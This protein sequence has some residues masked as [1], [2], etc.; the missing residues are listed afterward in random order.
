[1]A[2]I[3]ELLSS[4]EELK[5]PHIS[6][7]MRRTC[8]SVVQFVHIFHDTP[9]EQAASLIDA[10]DAHQKRWSNRLI[11]F[12]L[13]LPDGPLNLNSLGK[14]DGGLGHFSEKFFGI[15]TYGISKIFTAQAVSMVPG[16]PPVGD[17][18]ALLPAILKMLYEYFEVVATESILVPALLHK[19]GQNQQTNSRAVP[20]QRSER[21]RP[22]VGIFT[23]DIP[24]ENQ[25]KRSRFRS[26]SRREAC[27]WQRI[28]PARNNLKADILL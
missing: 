12:A 16:Q 18:K 6:T 1:M 15:H 28:L 17:M 7:R 9:Y 5:Y 24:F 8:S 2:R 25:V 23:K 21:S 14:L 19:P 20:Q 26:I 11:P 27:A 4:I 3:D 22:T 10:F 13:D